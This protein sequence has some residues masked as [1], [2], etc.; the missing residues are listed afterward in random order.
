[1]KAVVYRLFS[2]ADDLLYVGCSIRF[3]D[4]MAQH[5]GN[6]EW[7]GEVAKITLQHCETHRAALLAEEQAIR[8]EQP[9]YNFAYNPGA[10]RK[11]RRLWPTNPHPQLDALK[12]LTGR[13]DQ[14]TAFLASI[15]KDH[16]RTMRE[17]GELLGVGD[18]RRLSK[19]LRLSVK[20]LAAH[21]IEVT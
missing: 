16:M 17:T 5:S 9:R 2:A 20:Q 14:G 3:L 7:F 4:R 10:I 21:G 13:S 18:I 19:H 15:P 6:T 1:M 8:S 11:A 12:R